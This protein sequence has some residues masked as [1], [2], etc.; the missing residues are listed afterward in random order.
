[1]AMEFRWPGIVRALA[2]DK[3]LWKLVGKYIEPKI[4]GGIDILSEEEAKNIEEML[5]SRPGLD[6]Y[7]QELPGKELLDLSDDDF[8]ELVYYTSITREKRKAEIAQEV[9][10]EVLNELTEHEKRIL[11]LLFGILDG[12]PRTLQEI[13]REFNLTEERIYEIEGKALRKL[14]H[15]IRS[16][17]LRDLLSSIDELDYSSQAFLTQLFGID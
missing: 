11:Q 3:S 2:S 17:R 7:L 12:R 9:I 13:G 16:R 8:N 14:R 6:S 1:M 4:E 15:P 5:E 10:D